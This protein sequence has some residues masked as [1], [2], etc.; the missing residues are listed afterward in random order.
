MW[1]AMRWLHGPFQVHCVLVAVQ[2]AAA[3]LC[4]HAQIS[5]YSLNEE[6]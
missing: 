6:T 1:G 3:S 2:P 4:A 5:I